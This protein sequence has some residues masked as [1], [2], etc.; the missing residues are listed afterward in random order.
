MIVL[1]SDLYTVRNLILQNRVD[2]MSLNE[3]DALIEHNTRSEFVDDVAYERIM[4]AKRNGTD[5][6]A[7]GSNYTM[8]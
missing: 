4:E 2:S 5:R 3:I 8:H 1:T 6:E 7:A